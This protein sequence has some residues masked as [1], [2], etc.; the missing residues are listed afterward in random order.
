MA[1][2][3]DYRSLIIPASAMQDKLKLKITGALVR[4]PN[5]EA[6]RNFFLELSNPPEGRISASPYLSANPLFGLPNR[7]EFP[8]TGIPILSGRAPGSGRYS[9]PLLKGILRG[10]PRQDHSLALTIKLSLNPTRFARYQQLGRGI[11]VGGWERHLLFR[12]QRSRN[13]SDEEFPLQ[14]DNGR[15]VIDNL[16]LGDQQHLGTPTAWPLLLRAYFGQTFHAVVMTLQEAARISGCRLSAPDNF[17]LDYAETYWEIPSECPLTELSQLG[18]AFQQVAPNSSIT[19]YPIASIGPSWMGNALV[20]TARLSHA[21]KL[22]LYAKTNRR[23]RIEV[24]HDLLA[25]DEALGGARGGT[26]SDVTARLER[27]AENATTLTHATLDRLSR[28]IVRPVAGLPWYSLLGRFAEIPQRHISRDIRYQIL[29]SLIHRGAIVAPPRTTLRDAVMYL[30]RVGVLERLAGEPGFTVT[31]K[32]RFALL[33][34]QGLRDAAQ[35]RGI[36]RG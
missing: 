12:A 9:A 34:L 4:G 32:Y 13:T 28:R 29:S 2:L 22:K 5:A 31:S 27:L 36:L 16:L 6:R 15:D 3:T 30:Q 1:V 25:D 23:I 21:R 17:L 33:E 11:L 35:L 7:S 26:P 19:E 14:S 24:S 20:L 10:L 18:A 8:W